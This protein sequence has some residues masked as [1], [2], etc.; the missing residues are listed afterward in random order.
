MFKSSF[1][2]SFI[3][4]SSTLA[5]P[6]NLGLFFMSNTGNWTFSSIRIGLVAN[7]F[8]FVS[9]NDSERFNVKLAS[10]LFFSFLNLLV[11][12]KHELLFLSMADK[13]TWILLGVL[14]FYSY[15]M[16]L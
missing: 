11:K 5:S 9:M 4:I 8:L 3:L 10:D 13:S 16:F 15:F 2:L 7:G 1:Y 6:A 12:S 14:L